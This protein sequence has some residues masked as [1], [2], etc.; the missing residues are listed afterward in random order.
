MVRK[1]AVV[2]G[3]VQGVGF[4]YNAQAVAEKLGAAGFVRNMA[5]GSVEA[6]VEGDDATVQR[7][8]DWLASGPTWATVTSVDVVEQSPRGD[9]GFRIL[10]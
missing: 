3:E 10:S 5:D 2:R 7:M 1:R 4:R 9:T 6:E 8:L